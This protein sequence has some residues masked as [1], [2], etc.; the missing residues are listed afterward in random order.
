MFL[1]GNRSFPLDQPAELV[2][3]WWLP[4]DPA[5]IASGRLVYEP[6]ERIRFE[7]VAGQMWFPLGGTIPIIL[8]FTVDGLFVTLRNVNVMNQIMN[9]PGGVSTTASVWLVFVGMHAKTETE[10]RLHQLEAR[11]SQLPEW[12]EAMASRIRV[13]SHEPEH[14]VTQLGRSQLWH[15][16]LVQ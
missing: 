11:L 13:S 8:G 16:W 1:P 15:A 2:G 9:M 7:S 10:L 12:M 5:N 6:G 4:S 14:S 3:E